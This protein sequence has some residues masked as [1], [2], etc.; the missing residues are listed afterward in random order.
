MLYPLKLRPLVKQRIWGGRRLASL[1]E[2]PPESGLIGE[3]WVVANHFS[4]N[5]PIVNGPLAGKTLGEILRKHPYELLGTPTAPEN[6]PLLIK[7]LDTG[8]DISIQVHPDD[9]HAAR[10]EHARGKTELWYIMHASPE[11]QIVHGLKPGVT[12]EAF[13]RSITAGTVEER[14]HRVKVKAGD[15]FY[16]P[17]GLV[18][19][20][21]KDIL[22]AEIQ[23]NS[24]ITY[25]I[26]D[27]NRVDNNGLPR[28]LHIEKALA[29]IDYNLHPEAPHPTKSFTCSMFRVDLLDLKGHHVAHRPAG[30]TEVF[31][32]VE[33]SGY[34][35]ADDVWRL[36][37][38][39]ALVL[40]AC[41]NRITLWGNMKILRSRPGR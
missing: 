24:D 30:E 26:Y 29:V 17:P 25:R 37:T 38:G 3:A 35:Q 2:L 11:A 27:Y 32:I 7:L 9:N 13:T 5:S 40:P 19:A 20:L 6:F 12:P 14:L 4:D 16:I 41:L 1:Y 21:G 10:F 39:D 22:A 8:S 31:L 15:L 23:V 33:G 28:Q 18:H 36:K 34:L